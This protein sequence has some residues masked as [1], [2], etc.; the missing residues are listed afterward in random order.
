[1]RFLIVYHAYHVDTISWDVEE[2]EAESL[3][4]AKQIGKAGA[5]DRQQTCKTVD[6][7][8]VPLQDRDAILPIKLTL[9]E[10]ISGFFWGRAS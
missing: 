4:Q 1:M 3:K 2:V 8:V 5:Y 10:R 9:H 6:C 7:K